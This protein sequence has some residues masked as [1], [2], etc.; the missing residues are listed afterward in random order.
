MNCYIAFAAVLG[1]FGVFGI[2]AAGFTDDPLRQKSSSASDTGAGTAIADSQMPSGTPDRAAYDRVMRQALDYL[3]LHGQAEDGSFSKQFGPGITGVVLTGALQ[4]GRLSPREPWVAKGLKYLESFVKEDGGIYDNRH[5]CY[6]T[7]VALMAFTA[8][9]GDGRYNKLISNAQRYL[10]KIQW[11]ADESIDQENPFYG[12]IGYDSQ[13]RPDMS[14]TQFAIEAL[15]NSGT[16]SDDP[17]LQRALVFLARSQN[18]RSEHNVAPFTEAIDDDD[19][20]GFIYSPAGKA[21]SKAGAS[22]GGGLRSYGSM[23]YAGLKSMFYAAVD[24]SDPRVR[25]AVDWL[26]RHWSV[27][28]NPGMGQQGLYY[29]YHTMAKALATLGEDPFLDHS[30]TKH[31]WRIELFEEL[32]RR[33]NP[34][35]SWTNPADRWYEG[36][37]NLVTG[38]VLMAL[39]HCKPAPAPK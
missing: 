9:N 4:T 10:K 13:K 35:G 32:T 39:S 36:D 29:Y 37:P 6:T 19:Q 17:A 20:G 23:T 2:A 27:T 31:A 21:E 18:L 15:V 16:S 33:Q 25:G 38:Y 14:N 3:R 22:R 5:D 8:A 30:G 7:S 12:G 11:D 24:K 34:N 1:V 28:E 26:R